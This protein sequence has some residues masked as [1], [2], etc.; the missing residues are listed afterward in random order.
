MKRKLLCFKLQKYLNG[1]AYK[2]Q[3]KNP[4]K[5]IEQI[6]AINGGNKPEAIKCVLQN[7]IQREEIDIA[8]EIFKEALDEDPKMKNAIYP[9][10]YVLRNAEIKKMVLNLLNGQLPAEKQFKIYQ[11]LENGIKSKSINLKSIILGKKGDGIRDLSLA[12]IWEEEK[13]R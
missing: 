12:D 11:L 13:Q 10:E 9:M 4:R 8:N 3:F 7:L 1:Q 6:T 5:A 2:Y